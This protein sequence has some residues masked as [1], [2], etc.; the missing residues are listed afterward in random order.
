MGGTKNH[1]KLSFGDQQSYQVNVNIKTV[2][3]ALKQK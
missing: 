1:E 2:K 3:M